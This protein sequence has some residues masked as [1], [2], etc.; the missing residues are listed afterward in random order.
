VAE[1]RGILFLTTGAER[2]P[3]VLAT[4]QAH[5]P[6]LHWTIVVGAWERPVLKVPAGA[7]LL[8]AKPRGSRWSYLQDL[9][10][11]RYDV[12]VVAWHAD[13]DR[14]AVQLAALACGAREIWACDERMQLFPVG[15][16]TGAWWRHVR[17]RVREGPTAPEVFALL[18]NAL[19]GVT[20][21][22]LVGRLLLAGHRPP[23][24]P[25]TA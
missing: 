23:K 22:P 8:D 9:R 3:D 16:P 6:R 18:A 17:R 5:F 7:R 14:R 4:A 13:R 21:A 15:T 2:A 19:Y 20:L 25:G 1:S 24:A 10:R 12:A 11:S